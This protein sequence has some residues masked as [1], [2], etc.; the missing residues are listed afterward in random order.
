MRCTS[1]RTVGFYA[2][3]KTLCWSP[4][5]YSKEYPPFQIPCSKCISCRLQQASETALRC[6]HEAQ[7]HENNSFITLT[8]S[9]DHIGENRL[10]Y[11]DFQL[12]I[13]KL[14]KYISKETHDQQKISVFCSGEYGD[15][16]KRS[17][18]HCLIFG[19]K[20]KDLIP[21][22]KNHEGD[23]IHSS[24]TLDEIWGK[25]ITATGDI[26]LKSAG[27]C[28][29][30]ALKK[31]SHGHDSQDQYKPISKRS[32]KNA[33]GKKWIEKY[34]TDCFNHGYCEHEGNKFPIPR[35]YEKWLKKHNPSAWRRY[36]TEIK[37]KIIKEAI[38]KEE[39]ISLK[40]KLINFRRSGLKGLQIS[41]NVTRNKILELKSK[42][43][44][45]QKC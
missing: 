36:V 23:T 5:K 34:F 9:D 11:R 18:W 27:Y 15:K 35:Y 31:L 22:S 43:L 13:K 37:P 10:K 45:E 44:K 12:F 40:E 20:P 42:K 8:Y 26:T 19:W 32:S 21:Q 30:Y 16:T 28:A 41:R 17:H 6:V 25:G 38:A 33:I 29:R 24:N 14:R 2:D 1:P 3:G 39:K 7:M 4:K